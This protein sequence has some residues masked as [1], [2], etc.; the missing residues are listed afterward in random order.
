MDI[1]LVRCDTGE[2]KSQTDRKTGESPCSLNRWPVFE[3]RVVEGGEKTERAVNGILIVKA[4][5]E[6]VYLWL[7][8]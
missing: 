8:L 1:K 5:C 4:G 7:N 2:V 3:H 6:Q